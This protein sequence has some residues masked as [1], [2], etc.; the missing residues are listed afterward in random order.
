MGQMKP[1]ISII[2]PTFMHE[3]FIG[4][5]I[6]SVINQSLEDWELIIVNDGGSDDTEDIVKAYRGDQRIHYFYQ[7]NKGT[8]GARNYAIGKSRGDLIAYLDSDDVLLKDH[9][10]VRHDHL[11]K[12]DCDFAFGPVLVAKDGAEDIYHGELA[13]TETG[14][15]M[16][17]MVMHKRECFEVGM[18]NEREIFEEDLNLFLK[19]SRSF[20]VYQFRSPVTAIYNKHSTSISKLYELGGASQVSRYITKNK[21]S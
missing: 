9:L 2:M 5:A 12:E 16:P 15:V 7:D 18:F 8:S 3:E 21:R 13:D 1:K 6:Q 11:Q 20:A 10:S 14:C 17:L 19:M 4:N